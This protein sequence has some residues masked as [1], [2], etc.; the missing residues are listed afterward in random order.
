VFIRTRDAGVEIVFDNSSSLSDSGLDPTKPTTI[1]I[2]GFLSDS[3]S[4]MYL[5]LK[6]GN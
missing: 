4:L 3:T 2:N 5:A 6:N 1:I